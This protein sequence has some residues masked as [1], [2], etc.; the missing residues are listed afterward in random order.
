MTLPTPPTR[1]P[2]PPRPPPGPPVE[3]WLWRIVPKSGHGE[4]RTLV[5][6]VQFDGWEQLWSRRHPG[7]GRYRIEFRDVRRFIIEAR[8]AN[9]PDPRSGQPIRYTVGRVRRSKRAV[10]PAQ[11]A[12]K[13]LSPPQP[14]GSAAPSTTQ[15]P[16]ALPPGSAPP[17][18]IWRLRKNREWQLFDATLEVPK[19]YHLLWLP[20][21]E[22]VLV[23]SPHG[24]WP[25]YRPG[26]LTDGRSCLVPLAP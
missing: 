21:R 25:G 15:T 11:P 7:A 1:R 2:R 13:P 22:C 23:Y 18:R 24:T 4:H 12:W 9:V 14:S 16:Q 5:D 6:N 19:F 26:R 3:V 20:T 8:Y 10:P 17:G